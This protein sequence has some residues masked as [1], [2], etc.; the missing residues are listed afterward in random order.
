MVDD[1]ALSDSIEG[2]MTEEVFESVWSMNSTI[3][4]PRRTLE[5]AGRIGKRPVRILIDSGTIGINI[6]AQECTT[7]RIKIERE[8]RGKS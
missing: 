7:R 2:G 1:A 4:R 5:L 6:S 3:R 8:Q